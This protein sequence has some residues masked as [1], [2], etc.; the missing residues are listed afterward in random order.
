MAKFV[1]PKTEQHVQQAKRVNYLSLLFLVGILATSFY[2]FLQLQ[3]KKAELVEKTQMLADSTE[4]LRRIRFELE[5][6]QRGLEAREESTMT[7]MK[8]VSDLVIKEDYAEAE[9]VVKSFKKKGRKSEMNVNLYTFGVSKQDKNAVSRY[10][11]ETEFRVVVDSSLLQAPAWLPN[12]STVYFYS[13]S[14]ESAA[15]KLARG[16]QASTGISFLILQGKSSDAPAYNA[17]HYFIIHYVNS[18]SV[19]KQKEVQ[20][21]QLQQFQKSK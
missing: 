3:Q 8:Q 17:N 15:K 16:L 9:E 6:V 21:Q 11:N 20:V 5:T 14:A 1:D 19:V 2:F 12:Q 7:V 10:L 4:N 18:E 13:P